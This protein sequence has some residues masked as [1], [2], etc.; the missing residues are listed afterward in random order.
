MVKS[1][2]VLR[3]LS[4]SFNGCAVPVKKKQEKREGFIDV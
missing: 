4:L 3:Q 1:L 2:N